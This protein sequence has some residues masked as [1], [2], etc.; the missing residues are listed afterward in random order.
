M[1]K[2]QKNPHTRNLLGWLETGRLG[3]N[4]ETTQ[5]EDAEDAEEA[6]E[7]PAK[8]AKKGKG[9]EGKGKGKGKKEPRLG[10]LKMCYCV[11]Q[12]SL[13]TIR[14]VHRFHS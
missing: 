8:R 2:I 10:P 14:I 9:N 1:F 5:A 12:L 4:E 3:V 7:A 11:P 6:E 13:H